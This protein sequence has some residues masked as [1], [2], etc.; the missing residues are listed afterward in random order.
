MALKAAH[1]VCKAYVV[2]LDLMND[3]TELLTRAQSIKA[4]GFLLEQR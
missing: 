4:K 1:V 2:N 3:T